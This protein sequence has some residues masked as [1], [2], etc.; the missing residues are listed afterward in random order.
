[1]G[2]TMGDEILDTFFEMMN[3]VQKNP[4]KAIDEYNANLI[5]GNKWLDEMA[6]SHK[7]VQGIHSETALPIRAVFVGAWAK[8]FLPFEHL[9]MVNLINVLISLAVAKGYEK[10]EREALASL[11]IEGRENNAQ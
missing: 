9:D 8:V 1:M 6:E 7:T 3:E 5:K 11:L 2:V 4:S 10:G